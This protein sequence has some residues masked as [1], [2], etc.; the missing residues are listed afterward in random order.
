MIRTPAS[1]NSP[2]HERPSF[3]W[4]KLI[5]MIIEKACKILDSLIPNATCIMLQGHAG[6]YISERKLQFPNR[7]LGNK[8]LYLLAMQ[9]S[10]ITRI[11]EEIIT[12]T[13]QLITMLYP[14]I[15]GDPWSGTRVILGL[16]LG[17]CYGDTVLMPSDTEV[18]IYENG[19]DYCFV[20]LSRSLVHDSN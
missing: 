19:D 15:P 3:F 14:G 13:F 20:S 4:R 10:F 18:V 6:L 16:M 8:P 1:R 17:W 12:S 11:L 5:R 7:L 9:P 2:Y